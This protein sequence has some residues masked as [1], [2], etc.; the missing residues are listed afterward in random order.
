MAVMVTSAAVQAD[1]SE[2]AEMITGARN[3]MENGFS[4]PPVR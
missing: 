4:S 3:S 1:G 2:A